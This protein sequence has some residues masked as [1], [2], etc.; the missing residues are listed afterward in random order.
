MFRARLVARL[1]MDV[2]VPEDTEACGLGVLVAWMLVP[3]EGS[4]EHCGRVPGA[5]WASGVHS[6][7]LNLPVDSEGGFPL[8][9]V[10]P[11]ALEDEVKVNIC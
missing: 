11:P 7:L 8:G 9:R 5:L 1:V 2:R 4:L 10:R 3:G 6:G